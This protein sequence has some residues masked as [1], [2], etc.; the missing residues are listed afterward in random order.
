MASRIKVLSESMVHKIAAGEV[1]ERPASVVKELVENSIDARSQRIH[2]EIK[3]GGKQEIQVSDNGAG[4][5]KEDAELCILR[6][7]TSKMANPSDM[8]NI[9]TLGFRGEA[10][11]SIG[12]VSRMTIETRMLEEDEGTRVSVEGG[13]LR[14]I[15]PV[16]RGAG[17]SV[18]VRNM[19]FNTPARRK[20]LR[21]E[22]TETRHIS[23]TVVQLAAGHPDIG[24]EL[25]HQGRKLCDY[26][27]TDRRQ[28]AGE[29]LGFEPGELLFVE[30]DEGGIV[31]R[32]FLS[33]PAL[34]EKSKGKQFLVVR[35]RPIL[36][37][38][39]TQAIYDGY[40]GLIPGDFHPAFLVWL[41]LDPR[42]ID[43]NVHP[44]KREIR[45][46][47]EK[48]VV[49]SLKKGVRQAFYTPETPTI[50]YSPEAPGGAPVQLE[51]EKGPRIG[52]E[53]GSLWGDGSEHTFPGKIRGTDQ[54]SFLLGGGSNGVGI[55]SGEEDAGNEG[56]L[57]GAVWQI[58]NKYLCAQV[59]DGL[60]IVDQQA[61]HERVNFETTLI[62]LDVGE[63]LAG[64][65]LLIPLSVALSPVEKNVLDEIG[66]D[67]EK[68]GFAIRDFGPG[69]VLVEAIPAEMRNWGEEEEFRKILSDY[70]E[71]VDEI[72][73]GLKEKIAWSLS[74]NTS[75]R[76]GEKLNQE[77]MK[78]L[79]ERLLK[80]SEPFVCPRG[81]PTLVKIDSKEIDYLFFR[82]K[83]KVP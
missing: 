10:L 53:K 54:M 27:A 46:A 2:V 52:E 35:G 30:L 50:V 56:V 12:A 81:R 31:I 72:G 62:H 57:G 74:K 79:L 16:G 15:L 36:S 78:V 76:S 41:D 64:Q 45:L 70:L 38:R 14:E 60:I 19:F 55:P 58:Q 5:S 8:F 39:L 63:G 1:I 42:K 9:S 77:E 67:L 47:E 40:G 66:G 26:A 75:I 71:D 51:V 4:M 49:D 6:H 3:A 33:P 23:Q 48:V 34:S 61:A 29:L 7:A 25:I 13:I 21:H 18:T 11:A 68:L 22:D 44:T 24:F 82:K 20:F 69:T 59:K 65:Q 73:K 28:R 37:R 80:T 32:G 17:T 43:V 83:R